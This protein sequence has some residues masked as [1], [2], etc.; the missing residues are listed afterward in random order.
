MSSMETIQ[1][2][3]KARVL[4]VMATRAEDQ[5]LVASTAHKHGVKS[6]DPAKWSK[7]ERIVPC[8]GWH[9]WFS[10]Q[11]YLT[12]EEEEGAETKYHKPLTG[13]AKI[14]HYRSVLQPSRETPSGEDR[15]K[16]LSLPDPISFS[17]FLSRTRENLKKYPYALVGEIGLDRAFRIPEAWTDHPDLWSKRDNGLTPGGREGRRLTPFRTTPTHQK[18]IFKLQLQL[19]AEMGRAVSV[20]GV[21]A[22]G[23]VLEVLSDLWR[24]HE[25]EVLSKR[26]Q[27]KRRLEHPKAKAKV[28]AKAADDSKDDSKENAKKDVKDDTKDAKDDTKEDNKD[29]AKD[30]PKD[31]TNDHNTAKTT[32]KN[33]PATTPPYPPRICL[34][35]Y[36]G[37]ISNF[38]QYL[39]P[40]I[41]AHIFASFSTAINLSDAT[42]EETPASFVELIKTVPDHMLLVESDL[43]TA[44]EEMDRRLED[45]VRR[46][47]KIKGW[48]L[49]KGVEI[50]GRN[51]RVFAFGE[52][53]AVLTTRFSA[54]R[55]LL[56]HP[57]SDVTGYAPLPR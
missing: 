38:K 52:G 39:N 34:H 42:D 41:P 36:S 6:S 31:D 10:S 32:K 3:T 40:F 51:W 53:G 4:T 57:V 45:M 25:K 43:H 18:K 56:I 44:G 48:G 50:L 14:A 29:T 22:H 12:E 20:H 16:Y 28:E 47:C 54:V 9:P 30:D 23:L 5:D 1:Q 49:E 33:P 46:I 24:G 19:A 13:E 35:S 2:N 15:Q 7:E 11:M 26:E 8:F 21:Q 17:A 37:N 55:L 27:K